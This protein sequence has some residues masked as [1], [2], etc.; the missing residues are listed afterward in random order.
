MLA[1]ALL[2]VA[3]LYVVFSLAPAPPAEDPGLSA[4]LLSI[5]FDASLLATIAGFS[6]ARR[7]GLLASA[8]GGGML[9][10]GAGLCSLGGHTGGWLL[11]QYVTGATI[12]GIS[13]AAFR[14]Y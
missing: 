14:R 3:S 5:G 13:W 9:L 8:A 6:I 12:L 7:W 1:I 11:A 10:I 4:L 2:W